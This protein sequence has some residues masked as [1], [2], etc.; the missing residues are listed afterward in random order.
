MAA[1]HVVYERARVANAIVREKAGDLPDTPLLR[2][3]EISAIVQKEG[4]P[5]KGAT[6]WLV[7]S[8]RPQLCHEPSVPRPT[9]A[10]GS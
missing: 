7:P 1:L 4:K 6:V 5:M 9:V 2:A 8:G 10:P 3:G